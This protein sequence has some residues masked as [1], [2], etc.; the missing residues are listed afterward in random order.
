MKNKILKELDTE[1]VTYNPEQ[2]GDNYQDIYS[3]SDVKHNTVNTNEKNE[4][5]SR[6][7]FFN[8]YLNF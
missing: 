1:T 6:N 3:N 8:N 5:K 2:N 7:K 4:E